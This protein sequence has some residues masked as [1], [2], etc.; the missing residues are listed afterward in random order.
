M[1]AESNGRRAEVLRLRN[2]A[3]IEH[4]ARAEDRSWTDLL[5]RQQ[6]VARLGRK[7]GHELTSYGD[8]VDYAHRLKDDLREGPARRCA[9]TRAP[10]RRRAAAAPG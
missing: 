1:S 5:E 4:I 7:F 10:A 3:M 9:V 6:V 8:L 2:R